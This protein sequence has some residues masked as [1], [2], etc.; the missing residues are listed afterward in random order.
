MEDGRRLI[1]NSFKYRLLLIVT[2]MVTI[3]TIL[4]EEFPELQVEVASIPMSSDI[5]Y[6]EILSALKYIRENKLV[7]D[8]EKVLSGNNHINR[9]SVTYPIIFP[10]QEVDLDFQ[11]DW[12]QGPMFYVGYIKIDEN[13]QVRMYGMKITDANTTALESYQNIVNQLEELAKQDA[14]SRKKNCADLSDSSSDKIARAKILGS[15]FQYIRG[16]NAALQVIADID[17]T[18]YKQIRPQFSVEE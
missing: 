13:I 7:Q 14:E 3:E 18:E 5:R 8:S 11:V 15:H 16:L 4:K 9:S 1:S 10:C 17:G 2:N 6:D 12:L